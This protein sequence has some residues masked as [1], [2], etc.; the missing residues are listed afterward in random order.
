MGTQAV[1]D[2]GCVNLPGIR[3]TLADASPRTLMQLAVRPDV[4]CSLIASKV[5]KLKGKVVLS[6]GFE[7]R[8]SK[9]KESDR[10]KP[11]SCRAATAEQLW[12]GSTA[13]LCTVGAVARTSRG[14]VRHKPVTISRLPEKVN[15]DSWER[16]AVWKHTIKSGHWRIHG[17]EIRV[18]QFVQWTLLS[19]WLFTRVPAASDLFFTFCFSG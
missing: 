14:L 19:S 8:V 16:T 13:T 7:E 18:E 15:V 2:G 9:M 17:R 11:K 1:V 12:K 4:Y 6:K 10:L 5:R 3:K